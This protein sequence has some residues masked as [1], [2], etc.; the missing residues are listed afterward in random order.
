MKYF[1]NLGCVFNKSLCNF[2]Y[3]LSLSGAMITLLAL[4]GLILSYLLLKQKDKN[5]VKKLFVMGLGV[6]LF[7]LFTAPMWNSSNLGFY[8]YFYNDLSITLTIGWVAIFQLSIYLIDRFFAKTPAVNRF[9]L[10]LIPITVFTIMA[11]NMLAGMGI[12]SYAPE[13]LA[14]ST[15]KLGFVPIEVLYYAPVFGMLVL[16]FYFAW[17]QT[18]KNSLITAFKSE[19]LLSSGLILGTGITLY[20]LLIE[21]LVR[22]P[23]FPAWSYFYHDISFIR[24][25]LWVLMIFAG[26]WLGSKLV[27]KSYH[28]W[29]YLL[30][31]SVVFYIVEVVMLA[32]KGRIYTESVTSNF[33]GLTVPVLGTPV[34]VVLAIIFYQILIISFL[35][36]WRSVLFVK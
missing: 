18:A 27:K 12:R 34:E 17:T 9:F 23:G 30:S 24:I 11:E 8:S 25:G 22:T 26:M 36:Y 1:P 31:S 20:E 14:I 6:L 5:P 2:D 32:N 4:I 15:G 10:Y 21:P 33:T 28:F 35:K 3:R 19:N 13:V 7:E 29:V 16:S